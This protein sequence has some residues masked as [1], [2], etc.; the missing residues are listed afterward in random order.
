[1]I[2]RGLA[3][4]KVNSAHVVGAGLVCLMAATRYHHFGTAFSLPDASLAIFFAAGFYLPVAWLPCLFGEAWL[5]DVLATSGA[6][7]SYCMPP[8]YLF[9]LPTYAAL[10]FGGRWYRQRHTHSLRSLLPFSFSVVTATATAFL[11]SNGSF[12]LF[13]GRFP[14]LNWIEYAHGVTQYWSPYFV[15]MLTYFVPAALMHFVFAHVARLRARDTLPFDLR[16]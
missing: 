2:A 13:S 8:A 3:S 9:L 7:E 5:I 16:R 11:I 10:W 15:S 12:Y 6:A 1:M 14:H 4:T